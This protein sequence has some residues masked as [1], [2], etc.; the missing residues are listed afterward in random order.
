MCGCPL[1]KGALIP[2]TWRLVELGAS[3][4]ESDAALWI[5]W[6]LRSMVP[7]ILFMVAATVKWVYN[8]QS[9]R[10]EFVF[11][12]C[13]TYFIG[14]ACGCFVDI[15]SCPALQ[16]SAGSWWVGVPRFVG[17]IAFFAGAW[18]SLCMWKAEQFGLG[19]PLRARAHSHS[20]CTPA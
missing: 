1:A 14:S 11:W 5:E 7:G 12:I 16:L 20:S 18:A 9:T 4:P 10:R 17:A 15:C 19:T 13:L 8:W 3:T 6:V 2:C